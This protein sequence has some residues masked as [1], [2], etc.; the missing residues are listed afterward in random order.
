M[1]ILNTLP[2]KVTKSALPFKDFCLNPE[3]NTMIVIYMFAH[4]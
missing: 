1:R 4:L 3:N 2:W